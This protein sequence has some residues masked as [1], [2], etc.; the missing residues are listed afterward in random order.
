MVYDGI[1]RKFNDAVWVST[2]CLPTIATLLRGTAPRTWMVDLDIRDMFL[3]FMLDKHARELIGVD[4]I[5]FFPEELDEDQFAKWERWLHCA[6]G[7]KFPQ[8]M[9]SECRD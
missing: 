6:M 2:F 4:L 7:Q 1:A 5:H 3:N 8:T 9:P